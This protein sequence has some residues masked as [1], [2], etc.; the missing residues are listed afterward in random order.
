MKSSEVVP[1]TQDKKHNHYFKKCGYEYVDVYRVLEMFSVTDPCISHAAKKL[2]C[3]GQ[4]G[5][6]DVYTDIQ[7][8]ID[9]LERWKQMRQEDNDI[10]S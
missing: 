1:Q 7:D 9:T 5:H 3:T 6:K 2:L 8:V 4:R 10:S